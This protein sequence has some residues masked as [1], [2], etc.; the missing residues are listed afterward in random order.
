LNQEECE[1]SYD[2]LDT[3]DQDA[4]SDLV[5]YKCLDCG[6]EIEEWIK[7]DE[8]RYDRSDLD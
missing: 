4:T 1:H 5:I 2:Y 3:V 6:K 7:R 8:P